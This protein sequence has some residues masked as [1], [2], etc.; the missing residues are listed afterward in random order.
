MNAV[1]V[2]TS[3]RVPT[4]HF[5]VF[6]PSPCL[7]VSVFSPFRAGLT[8]RTGTTKIPPGSYRCQ[9][10]SRAD[11]HIMVARRMCGAVV[12]LVLASGVA[13]PQLFQTLP[14]NFDTVDANS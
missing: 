13:S 2:L 6:L 5:F 4:D 7:R 10:M 11:L 1:F 9:P 3:L 8:V 12:A 14:A